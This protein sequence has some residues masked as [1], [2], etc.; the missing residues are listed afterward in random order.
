MEGRAVEQIRRAGSLVFFHFP[1][2]G[3]LPLGLYFVPGLFGGQFHNRLHLPFGHIGVLR[4]VGRGVH[5]AAAA[6]RVAAQRGRLLHNDNARAFFGGR[7]RGG[8]ARAAAA[9]DDHVGSL[10]NLFSGNF[11]LDRNGPERFRVAARLHDRVRHGCHDAVA[12]QRRAGDRI[13]RQ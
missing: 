9:Q 8:H 5:V 12:R 10:V 6:H 13:D 4:G 3:F 7:Y 11:L 2:H 1:E